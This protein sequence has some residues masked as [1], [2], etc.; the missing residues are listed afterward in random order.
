MTSTSSY[1]RPSIRFDESDDFFNLHHTIV[2]N[3][4]LRIDD[5]NGSSAYDFNGSIEGIICSIESRKLLVCRE[6]RM[7][8]CLKCYF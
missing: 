4:G 1:K 3:I 7:I 2:A 6:G 5:Y 8:E